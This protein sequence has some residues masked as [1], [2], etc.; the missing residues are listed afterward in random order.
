MSCQ[1]ATCNE[2]SVLD[3]I[4]LDHPVLP[5][6]PVKTMVPKT[7]FY[8]DWNHIEGHLDGKLVTVLPCDDA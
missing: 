1:L 5:S 2:K 3:C 7:G 4:K 6:E 8:I